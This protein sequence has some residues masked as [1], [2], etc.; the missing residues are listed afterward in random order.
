MLC[1]LQVPPCNHKTHTQS[2]ISSTDAELHLLITKLKTELVDIVDVNTLDHALT[3]AAHFSAIVVGD[4]LLKHN[5]LLLPDVYDSFLDKLNE[6]I[7]LR[8]ISGSA[9]IG[10]VTPNWL[11]SQLS[12][13]LDHHMTYRCSVKKYGTVLCCHD[14]DLLHALNVSLGQMRHHSRQADHKRKVSDPV[15]AGAALTVRLH[16][17]WPYHFLG[18]MFMPIAL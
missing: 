1:L 12:S 7:Q 5:A 13:L 11:R 10:V 6:I 16:R 14:G 2:T 15:L 8:G 18:L 9:D 17:P 3:Y 4:A